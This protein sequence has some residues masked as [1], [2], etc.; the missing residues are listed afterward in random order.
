M[1][2][3]DEVIPARA[4]WS[5]VVKRG[6]VL[7]LTDLEGRQAVDFL[8]YNAADYE[9]RYA[10]ADT[11]KINGNIFV[12]KGTVLYSVNCNPMFTVIEDTC[13]SHDTIGG[14][15]SSALNRRRYGK[16]DDPSCRQNFLPAARYGM[17]AATWSRISTFSCTCR[18]AR[19]A[20]WTW[21]RALK[22]GDYVELRA[23]MD[24]L[25]VVSNCPQ[26]NNPVND[27]N[28]T[29]VRALVYRGERPPADH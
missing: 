9:D 27:F 6:E 5:R 24:V 26:M 4:G 12:R 2:V 8:C 17:G 14:C 21:G 22:P 25:A 15:C 19:T 23:E 10:A 16:P 29:P 13:G 20:P 7:R 1:I 18:S 11:M 28:P 3:M